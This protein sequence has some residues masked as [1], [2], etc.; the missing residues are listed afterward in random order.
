MSII[1]N[2]N[3]LLTLDITPRWKTKKNRSKNLWQN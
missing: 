2:N 3:I 1:A